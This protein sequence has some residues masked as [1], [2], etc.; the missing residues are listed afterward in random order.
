MTKSDDPREEAQYLVI[1]AD[2]LRKESE[3]IQQQLYLMQRSINSLQAAE[4]SL[5]E[6]K[7]RGETSSSVLIPLGGGFQAK[8][9]IP[10]TKEVLVSI[11]SGLYKSFPLSEAL[12]RAGKHS[13]TL[14]STITQ[15]DQQLSEKLEQLAKINQEIETIARTETKKPLK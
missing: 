15:L 8:A 2:E 9:E 6:L 14:Q 7:K 4:E 3:Y 11:G 5:Q 1:K 10:Q 13:E 12:K